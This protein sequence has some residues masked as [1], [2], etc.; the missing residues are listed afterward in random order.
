MTERQRTSRLFSGRHDFDRLSEEAE[1]LVESLDERSHLAQEEVVGAELLASRELVAGLG[2]AWETAT[3]LGDIYAR[4][5]RYLVEDNVATLTSLLD[6]SARGRG[7]EVI[8][9]HLERRMGHVAEGVDQGIDLLSRHNESAWTALQT[10]WAPFLA[11]VRQ[12]W[13]SQRQRDR[14]ERHAR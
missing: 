6:G 8:G 11:V 5:A 3:Q 2:L 14:A 9:R 13:A 10:L 12:D 1:A 4:Q 7:L